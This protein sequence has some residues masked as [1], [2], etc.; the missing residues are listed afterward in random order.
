MAAKSALHG[1]LALEVATFLFAVAA[2]AELPSQ[3][4]KEV[5]EIDKVTLLQIDVSRQISKPQSAKEQASL[6]DK[7]SMD[8]LACPRI[9]DGYGLASDTQTLLDSANRS[10]VEFPRPAVVPTLANTTK[11]AAAATA[12]AASPPLHSPPPPTRPEALWLS[13][14]L[15]GLLF[16]AAIAGLLRHSGQRRP[17]PGSCEGPAQGG[18]IS[19]GGRP[20]SPKSHRGVKSDAWA[21]LVGATLAGDVARFEALFGQDSEALRDITDSWGCT[22]LHCAARVGSAAVSHHLLESGAKVHAVE[23]WDETP[24]HFAARYGHAHVC[25]LLLAYGAKIDALNGQDWTPLVVAGVA[26]HDAV[27]QLLIERGAGVASLEDA[28]LPPQLARLLLRRPPPGCREGDQD[29]H[30]S[31]SSPP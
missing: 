13:R 8:P 1:F 24:L 4:L 18:S 3:M 6:G 29:G 19:C 11:E 22:T 30:V 2:Q 21:G 23:A 28:E 31:A 10:L 16:A 5:A 9:D 14:G 17:V 12:A 25:E 20:Q 26:G 15:A 7:L 27:C